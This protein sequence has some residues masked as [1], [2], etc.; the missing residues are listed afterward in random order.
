[1]SNAL[2]RRLD[3]LTGYTIPMLEGRPIRF[4][5]DR[6]DEGPG[7]YGCSD[8]S[9]CIYEVL[10][11]E[12]APPPTLLARL[13]WWLGLAELREAITPTWYVHWRVGRQA[14]RDMRNGLPAP[15]FPWARD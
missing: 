12:E 9:C 6:C 11:L 8:S 5:P 3:R 7:H 13:R 4:S 15:P 1:M 14:E 10:T 2:T